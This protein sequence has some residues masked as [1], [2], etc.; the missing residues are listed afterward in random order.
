VVGRL[1]D[2]VRDVVD[3]PPAD[4]LQRLEAVL[5]AGGIVKL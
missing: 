2:R 1:R 3:P 5:V 4:L